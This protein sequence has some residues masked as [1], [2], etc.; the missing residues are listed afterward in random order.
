MA[1]NWYFVGNT[2][3]GECADV[4]AL[5]E[6]LACQRQGWNLEDCVVIRVFRDPQQKP[7]T[8][9]RQPAVGRA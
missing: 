6:D 9:G 4:E 7:A 1:H 2:Q 5:S 3:T 8:V